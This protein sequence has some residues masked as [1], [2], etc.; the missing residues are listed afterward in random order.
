MACRN[1]TPFL[2]GFKHSAHL[3]FDGGKADRAKP[4]GDG[5]KL[6]DLNI[7]A[8]TLG[9]PRERTV[10]VAEGLAAKEAKTKRKSQGSAR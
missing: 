10:S 1:T 7:W 6:Y 3:H 9:R 8:M 5:S 4:C 2:T